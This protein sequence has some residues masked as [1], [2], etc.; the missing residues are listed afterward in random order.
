VANTH[1]DV[2]I[3]GTADHQVLTWELAEQFVVADF[4][5]TGL[6]D[7]SAPIIPTSQINDSPFRTIP[8][9]I[10]N[11][12]PAEL[13]MLIGGP[14]GDVTD[15]VPIA[16]DGHAIILNLA[17][18][19]APS[20]GVT[21]HD[22]TITYGQLIP[23]PFCAGPGDYVWV[24]GPVHLEQ[25]VNQT[26]GGT[27]TMNFQAKGELSVTPMNPLT[28]EPV[29]ETMTAFVRQHHKSV[30]N[31]NYFSG[32]GVLYQRLGLPTDAEGGLLFT[33]LRVSSRGKNSFD[34]IVRCN[35][36]TEF[37]VP[38]AGEAPA[39]LLKAGSKQ[40]GR[41]DAKMQR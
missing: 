29:G 39:D 1:L 23:K 5:R 14:M 16:T 20:P 19:E 24:A 6:L 15:D 11:G 30:M 33:R 3:P 12:L 38:V 4:M 36:E 34:A 40:R 2:L 35:S 26:A 31:D 41:A 8:A 9:V 25:S 37:P 22:F 27:F 28:G 32:D 18:R 7:S 17:D 21:H 10:Y 13:R